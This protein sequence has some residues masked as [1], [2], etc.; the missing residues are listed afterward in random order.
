[1]NIEAILAS[2]EHRPWPL[3][4]GAWSFYQEWN[5][6]VFLHWRVNAVQLRALLPKGLE[7]DLFDGDAWVSVV[8]FT[9]ERIRPR[10]LPAFPPIS[11]FNELNVRTYVLS[12]QKAGV[13][14]LSIE[15]ANKVSC[16]LAGRLS[17]LPYRFAHITRSNGAFRSNDPITRDSIDLSYS[18]TEQA[19]VKTPL[20]RWLTERYALY[21]E[22]KGA[23]LRYDTHHLEWPLQGMQVTKLDLGHSRMNGL[24]QGLPDVVHYSPGVAVLAWN[25]RMS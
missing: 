14:F 12:G 4:E 17:V 25:P 18:F 6:A 5:T 8:A 15:A 3:P 22:S 13:Y 23:M 9:M 19:V 21:Q 1:M 24:V 2:T 7:L 11:D 16:W 20:D 10:W